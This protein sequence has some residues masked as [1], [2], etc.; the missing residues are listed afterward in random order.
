MDS[1]V[2]FGF[3]IVADSLAP[4]HGVSDIE[5]VS[6]PDGDYLIAG[7]ELQGSITSF[8]IEAGSLPQ[9]A[10]RI[11]R[12]D[13]SG[14][15]AL[16]DLV[17]V[18]RLDG[19]QVLTLGR[20]DDNFGLFDLSASGGLTLAQELT[21]AGSLYQRG[22]TGDSFA[23]GDTSF[24]YTARYGAAGF[25]VLR[26]DPTGVVS[27]L[28]AVTDNA[29]RRLADVTDLHAAVLH[30]QQM[31]FTVSALEPG[32][33]SFTVADTG[34]AAMVDRV[35]PWGAGHFAEAT[36]LE[37][38]QIGPRAFV[39]MAA[40]GSDSITVLRV[41]Q[42]A[43]LNAVDDEEDTLA[44]RF[45][46]V[47]DIEV[48]Q[49]EDR[50][51]VAAAGSDD[52]ITLFELTY[53]GKLVHLESVRDEFFTTLADV[54]SLE[55]HV[56]G[57]TA[58]VFAGSTAE[59]GVTELIVDLTRSGEDL[60]GGPVPEKLVGTPRDDVIWGMGRSDR[61][62]G[63]NGDDRLIDGRGRDVLTG[64]NGSDIFEFLPDGRTDWI[65]DFQPGRD[66]IDLTDFDHVNHPSSVFMAPRANGAVIK[67]ADDIIRLASP[68]GL[69][70]DLSEWKDDMFIFG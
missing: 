7:S 12:S 45:E 22:F 50:T 59:D 54:S 66:R 63:R 8:R 23:V 56:V 40:A 52:G 11:D 15:D 49:T 34:R 21:D 32:I 20:Y 25:D 67:V 28:Q 19:V 51:F 31:L 30:G 4:V 38:V 5:F 48:F 26:I 35:V 55:V 46:G 47:R 9:V 65:T 18:P 41:S 42:G 1:I 17:L 2:K 24:V 29:W 27:H 53:R 3:V 6:G 69:P 57:E 43:K 13:A 70:W 16:S 68:D 58:H 64:G 14:T 62:V 37:T 61:L 10:A 39:L 36:D 60:R 33:H 44:T